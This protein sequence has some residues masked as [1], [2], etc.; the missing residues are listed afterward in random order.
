MKD[1]KATYTVVEFE[2]Y[3]LI[4]IR[5]LNQIG[6]TVNDLIAYCD[7]VEANTST[8][9]LFTIKMLR[10]RGC[11]FAL[12]RLGFGDWFYSSLLRADNRYSYQK[13]GGNVLFIRQPGREITRQ[14]I[15]QHLM[16]QYDSMDVDELIELLK[17]MYAIVIDLYD[18]KQSIIGTDMYYD[19]I[20]RKLYKNYQV[21][22]EE[23]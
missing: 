6:V 21:Y 4:H 15:L 22:F 19:G 5:R 16:D 3:Q 14:D 7:E 23:V 9:E 17:D 12:D 18:I 2:P 11:S 20:M 1:L 10:D 13:F 8:D